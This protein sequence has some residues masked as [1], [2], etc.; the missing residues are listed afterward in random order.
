MIIDNYPEILLQ[1]TKHGQNCLMLSLET[2]DLDII[3]A[4]FN[5]LRQLYNGLDFL[6]ETDNQDK[7]VF[8]HLTLSSQHA[9]FVF[10]LNQHIRWKRSQNPDNHEFPFDQFEIGEE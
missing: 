9:L 3:L 5:K 6:D 10:F 4:I 8:F 2:N 7:N 1:K